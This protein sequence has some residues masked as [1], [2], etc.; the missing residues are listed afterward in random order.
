MQAE[1][2]GVEDSDTI[3]DFQIPKEKLK[4]I[5]KWLP[6]FVVFD[7]Y[8]LRGKNGKTNFLETDV[9]FLTENLPLISERTFQ[10][11]FPSIPNFQAKILLYLVEGY[12]HTCAMASD[13]KFF[14][15][16]GTCFARK[17]AFD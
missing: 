9:W 8:T 10:K 7:A 2:S 17:S 6:F 12:D 13:T 15:A 3:T 4:E 16:G 1:K 11:N 14:Q 5:L